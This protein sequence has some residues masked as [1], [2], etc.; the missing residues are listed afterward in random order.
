MSQ[1][2]KKMPIPELVVLAQNDDIKALEEL[3]RKIQQD[4]YATLSYMLNNSENISDLTQEVLLKVAKNIQ[5]LKNP[6]CF[7]GWLNHIVTNSYYDSLRKI[8]KIPKILYFLCFWA[9]GLCL[10]CETD[11]RPLNHK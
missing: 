1:P 11:C 3:I 5:G 4:V 9:R 2:Y 7:R 10:K 6:K 8:K